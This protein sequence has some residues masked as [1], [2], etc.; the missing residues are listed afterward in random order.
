MDY[1]FYTDIYLGSAISQK[2]FP[3]RIAR[4]EAF[5]DRLKSCCRVECAGEEAEKMALCAVAEAV[6][7]QQKRQGIKS[8]SV[9]GVSVSYDTGAGSLR[10]L[11]EAA[12]VYLDIYRVVG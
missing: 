1:G 8:T 7:A 9:G 10:G 4:A 3:G 12:A 5:L 6:Q 11:Y 2:A